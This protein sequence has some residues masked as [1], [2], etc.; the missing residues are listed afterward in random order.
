MRGSLRVLAVGAVLA[1]GIVAIPSAAAAAPLPAC[2]GA[3]GW[4]EGASIPYEGFRDA[5][6]CIMRRGHDHPG[7]AALQRSLRTCYGLSLAADA[8]FGPVTEAAL[9]TAQRRAGTTADG[10]Y[11]P[12]TRKAILHKRFHRAGCMRVP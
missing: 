12:A 2:N 5:D 3:R 11:G 6:D 4:L 10:V 9:K 7:V 8:K 1:A